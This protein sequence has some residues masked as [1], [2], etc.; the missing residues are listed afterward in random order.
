M[1]SDTDEIMDAV[2][3]ERPDVCFIQNR[4]N[5]RLGALPAVREAFNVRFDI[6]E[7]S[8]SG[9]QNDPAYRPSLNVRKGYVGGGS[10]AACTARPGTT[11]PSERR[12]A[13][14]LDCRLIANGHFRVGAWAMAVGISRPI[15]K[16]ITAPMA[17]LPRLSTAALPA[18]PIR[19]AGMT[20]TATRSTRDMSGTDR[21]EESPAPRLLW[22]RHPV[23]C[24]GSPRAL[25]R[26]RQLPEPWPCWQ[27]PNE[28]ARRCVWKA[29]SHVAFAKIADDLYVELT[30]LVKPGDDGNFEMVQLYR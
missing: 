15:G 1:G 17:A 22:R 7:G 4:V 24:P 28:R 27:Y 11:G 21:R 5:F 16:S 25:L 14:S 8:M 19:Q 9:R 30:G 20:C 26:N 23:R 18:I 13:R 3:V 10:S 2:A 12:L 6:Y 29:L